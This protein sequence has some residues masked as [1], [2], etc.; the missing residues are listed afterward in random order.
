MTPPDQI[1][2]GYGQN[3]G[4]LAVPAMG[5][6][7]SAYLTPVATDS[8]PKRLNAVSST[9]SVP[10][11]HLSLAHFHGASVSY[12]FSSLQYLTASPTT[13]FSTK[14]EFC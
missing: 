12:R 10:S 3:E 2:Q 6:G 9:D 14:I 13:S 1:I 4:R 7:A 11:S 5:D 8:G